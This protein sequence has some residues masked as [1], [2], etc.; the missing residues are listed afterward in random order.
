M[1]AKRKVFYTIN[2]KK[3]LAFFLKFSIVSNL[4]LSYYVI[5]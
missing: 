1:Q 3:T 2:P 4:I 5:C